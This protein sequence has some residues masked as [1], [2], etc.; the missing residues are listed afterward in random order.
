MVDVATL[1]DF[2]FKLI[3][4]TKQLKLAI[5]FAEMQE[6]RT[7]LGPLVGVSVMG[8]GSSGSRRCAGVPLG[9]RS[10][11]NGRTMGSC[12]SADL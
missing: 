11:S 1:K 3:L 8:R 5:Q 10:I 9:Q 2:A 12:G 7:F 6:E 4:A